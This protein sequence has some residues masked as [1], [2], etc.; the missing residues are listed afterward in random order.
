M[1]NPSNDDHRRGGAPNRWLEPTEATRLA[2]LIVEVRVA[3]RDGSTAIVEVLDVLR[4]PPGFAATTVQLDDPYLPLHVGDV[5]FLFLGEANSRRVLYLTGSRTVAERL[6]AGLSPSEPMPTLDELQELADR[7]DL[8]VRGLAHPQSPTAASL[9]V[10]SVAA[11]SAVGRSA[12]GQDKN[13]LIA[14][15]IAAP[16][17]GSVAGGWH[18]TFDTGPETQR[19]GVIGQ[20]L[21]RRDGEVWHIL[22]PIHPTLL[23]P[24]IISELRRHPSN[25]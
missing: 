21:L 4:R 17:D 1:T 3:S 22:N 16:A 2:G 19:I 5:M 12:L 23:T 6:V 13:P 10:L 8:L 25:P 9:E 18:W 7:C 20:Y 15:A 24:A 11:S 14:I